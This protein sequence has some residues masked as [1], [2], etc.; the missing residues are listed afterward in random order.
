MKTTV[1]ANR[2]AVQVMRKAIEAV[3]TGERTEVEIKL[4]VV[5]ERGGTT[6][7]GEEIGN[8]EGAHAIRKRNDAVII[9]AWEG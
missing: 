2:E 8:N 7:D 3:F 1:V 6:A 9:K 5:S 4:L